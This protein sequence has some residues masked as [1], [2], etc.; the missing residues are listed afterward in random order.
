ML[1]IFNFGYS[2]VETVLT[3]RQLSRRFLKISRDPYIQENFT[4]FNY[5]GVSI[6]VRQKN[7]V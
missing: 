7:D 4:S 6:D 3:M 2:A 5:D 1:T